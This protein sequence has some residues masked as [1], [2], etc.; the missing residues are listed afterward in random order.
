MMAPAAKI[1]SLA[2]NPCRYRAWGSSE[3]SSSPSMA[4]KP[5]QGM[6]RR[7]YSVSPFCF[8]HRAGPMPMENSLTVTPQALAARKWPSSWTAIS[9]PKMKM[10]TRIYTMVV[11][12]HNSFI[13]S[14]PSLR[15][16]GPDG[17]LPVYPQGLA[18]IS[19]P[20]CPTPI[21]PCGG[22]R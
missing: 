7:A 12:D 8:F 11:I 9:T 3:S 1:S 18:D 17:L 20:P 4:Q 10:A 6:A 19:P 2:Q 16:P 15:P 14:V 5:P 13:V 22:C 21:P